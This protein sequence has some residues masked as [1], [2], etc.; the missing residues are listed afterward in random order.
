MQVSPIPVLLVEDDADQAEVVRRTLQRQV[1]PF[2]VTVVPDG[3][4]CL[5]TL[6]EA[7]FAL[8]LLDYSL[9]HMHG[10]DVL[11]HIRAS[12]LSVPVV[13]V[14]GQ[15]DERIAVEALQA[16][17]MD[18]VIK[19]TGYRTTLPSVLHKVLKQHELAMENL[20]L[21]AEQATRAAR[22]Q[23]LT[24]LNQLISS[25]LD[26]DAVL[27][28]IASAAA[29][30]MPVPL[31]QFWMA[32]PATQT[33]EARAFSNDA[34]GQSHPA[35]TLRF[36]QGGVGWIARH[37]QPLNIP[38]MLEDERLLAHEWA[39]QHGLT[40]FY[41]VPVVLADTLLAV[42]VLNGRQPFDLEVDDQQMLSCL[43]AQAATAI[44]NAALYEAEAA[45]R[46]AAEAAARVKSAFLANMSHEIRTPMN[47]ILGMAMLTLDT[48]LTPEQR[49][50]LTII[51]TAADALL[52]ILN[53]ILD[54]SRLEAGKL[55]LDPV[56]FSLQELL[57]GTVKTLA[58]RA[59]E[60]GLHLAYEIQPGIPEVL[61]GDTGRLRQVIMNLTGNAIKFTH[62]GEVIITVQRATLAAELA[63]RPQPPLEAPLLLQV[64]IRDT[65]IGIP[66][67]KHSSIFE[68]F[69]QSDTS[70]TRQYGGTGLGLTISRQLVELLGGRLWVE[71]QVGV[72]STFSFTVPLTPQR[73][74]H[75]A[76]PGSALPEPLCEDVAVVQP[77]R[78][79]AS[80]LRLH[81][82]VVED[83]VVNQ[84]LV[85]RLLEKRGHRV[86]AVE[87]GREALHA[88]AQHP[89]DVILMDVQMPDMDGFETT[90]VLRAQERLTGSHVPIIALT[91][92]AMQ[93][94]HYKCLAAG[95]DAY[96]TKPIKPEALYTTIEHVL[97]SLAVS[98]G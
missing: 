24:R 42:L 80:A 56:A 32:D 55:P 79:L 21:Y 44:H 62:E 19:T 94:D 75:R 52:G 50:N 6:A 4:A 63:L 59:R 83:N 93:E 20:R 14:T 17:A 22:L 37:R 45:A 49:E 3:L 89:F 39:R 48:A 87:T 10:L 85:T 61:I 5:A 66:A 92:H 31:V 18:Y 12:G 8:V 97:A 15:G 36:E 96:T 64:D 16:G 35:K 84:R 58:L 27:R 11:A 41:G 68:A 34:L 26:M 30:L 33:L 25:S 9:P 72:G 46:S 7:P 53:D 88:Y 81:I 95:M 71:S 43:V 98:H 78:D 69:S 54:V 38:H 57:D 67:V 76:E 73:Q 74:Q 77:P 40:S 86:L 1:P 70:T 90:R 91:A 2:A 29:T 13:M 23:T 82:L 51:H 65:G 60:K 28:E 47:A